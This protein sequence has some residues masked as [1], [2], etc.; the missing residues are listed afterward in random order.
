MIAVLGLV[1]VLMLVFNGMTGLTMDDYHY[2]M[3]LKTYGYVFG[4]KDIFESLA[5]LRRD[6]N[7]RVFAHFFAQLFLLL[8]RWIFRIVNAGN[9]TLLFWLLYRYV[10]REDG[11]DAARLVF[12][13]AAVWL[14]LPAWGQVFLWLTG[15]CNYSWTMTL[16]FL[17]LAPYFGAW[18]GRRLPRPESA[19]A[20]GVFLLLAFLAGAYSENGALAMLFTAFC[21]LLLLRRREGRFDRFLS[22]AFLVGCGGFLFLM[23]APSELGGRRG[24]ASE[25]SVAHSLE[26]LLAAAER[27]AGR[28]LPGW[29]PGLLVGLA[30]LAAVL[31]LWLARRRKRLVCRLL[32]ALTVLG[33]T[34]LGLLAAPPLSGMS[35]A[36]ALCALLN[37]VKLSLL[38]VF[39]L[40]ALL[41]LAAV[42][43]D[44]DRD[45]L[46]CALVLG[47]AAFGSLAVFLF[48]AYFPARSA[49]PAVFYTV[50]AD[51]LLLDALR[52]RGH[53]RPQR[54]LTG[55]LALAALLSLA[56]AVPDLISTGRGMWQRHVLLDSSRSAG[57]TEIVI[58]PIP[59]A[60]KYS[61]H[62]PGD[63]IYFD[64]DICAYYGFDRLQ[65]TGHVI[66]EE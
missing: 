30:L 21:L 1:F 33:C 14:L 38:A 66:E 51:V 29:L 54:I 58:E 41:L 55:A 49:C 56:L 36:E 2:S 62:W 32:A 26:R 13:L 45:T 39:G 25:S 53:G 31:L 44:A 52:E 16:S 27:L 59:V 3:N 17:F 24:A 65:I 8:P 11:R 4:L 18:M 60:T 20:K 43:G 15:A 63:Q 10:R 9:C 50:L 19:W 46:L 64:N 23:L 6:S 40:Y 48:A 47:L 28:A 12:L 22:A 5:V 37:D 7:G 34:A 35:A 57:A 42:A 61:A